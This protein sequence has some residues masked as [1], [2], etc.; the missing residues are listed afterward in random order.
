M[1]NV[2]RIVRTIARILKEKKAED[3][4]ILDMKGLTITDY[5][6]IAT[7]NSTVHAGALKDEIERKL[8][9]RGY[10]PLG[11][12]GIPYNHWILM[13]YGDVVV[14]IFHPETRELYDLERLWYD[15]PRYTINE[16]G[17]IEEA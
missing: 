3:I 6:I 11:I 4:L 5:F 17:E 10:Y 7:A 8:E 2:P 12:E 1:G 15:A 16:K 14:H 13:D 9:L